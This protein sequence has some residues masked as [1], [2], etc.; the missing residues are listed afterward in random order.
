MMKHATFDAEELRR[1]ARSPEGIAA[2]KA[3]REESRAKLKELER[4]QRVEPERLMRQIT[5]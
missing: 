3:I 1:W 4:S 5:R 2:I